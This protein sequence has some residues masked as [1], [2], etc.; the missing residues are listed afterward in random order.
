LAPPRARGR[1]FFSARARGGPPAAVSGADWAQPA[2]HPPVRAL[3]WLAAVTVA[4]M[5]GGIALG[6]AGEV[7]SRVEA[8]AATLVAGLIGVAGVVWGVYTAHLAPDVVMG[9]PR[10]AALARA[11]LHG[12][13]AP[14][15][16]VATAA[17]AVGLGA[18]FVLAALA[19]QR[20]MVRALGTAP[21]GRTAWSGFALTL[22]PAGVLA[23]TGID[24]W[25]LLILGFALAAATLTAP[26]LAASD[27]RAREVGAVVGALVFV[28]AAVMLGLPRAD[29]V[30]GAYPALVAAPL[31]WLAARA[32][33]V[34]R[35]A[36]ARRRVSPASR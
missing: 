15:S 6:D 4:F 28:T 36:P 11:P 5:G 10:L 2:S 29:D 12:L 31:A 32:V 1:G 30:V 9:S 34:S 25:A 23:L 27:A 8:V 3:A 22:L 26:A 19:L 24:A 20:V 18:S 33:R 17:L 14:L 35:P 16:T 7:R 13:R 21:A